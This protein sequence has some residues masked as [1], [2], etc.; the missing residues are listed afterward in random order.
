MSPKKAGI[1]AGIIAAFLVA[2]A[3]WWLKSYSIAELEA[4]IAQTQQRMWELD[5]INQEVKRF[6]HDKRRLET[7]RHILQGIR[8]RKLEPGAWLDVGVSPPPGVTIDRIRLGLEG[9]E[10]IGAAQ[11]DE[12]LESLRRVLIEGGAQSL[13]FDE[14]P[15]AEPSPREFLVRVVFP[16]DSEDDPS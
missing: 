10:I 9:I 14:A 4:Q 8:K 16:S 7:R 6:Q 11:S 13:A 15:R 12:A 3:G 1:I 5:V 2:A